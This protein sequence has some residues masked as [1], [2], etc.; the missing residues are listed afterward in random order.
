MQEMELNSV[1]RMGFESPGV[2]KTNKKQTSMKKKEIIE[3]V[4]TFV[5]GSTILAALYMWVE[6]L[7]AIGLW[8]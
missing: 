2:H 1:G 7:S 4:K 8:N 6:L 3:R 5:F